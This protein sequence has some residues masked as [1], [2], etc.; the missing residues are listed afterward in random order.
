MMGVLRF[1]LAWLVVLNHVWLPVANKL[2][3]HAVIAFYAIS[4]YL[5]T[6]VL[7]ETYRGGSGLWRYAVNRF[8]R[9][10]PVYWLV[11]L[12][13]AVF[14]VAAPRSFAN[15]N[16]AIALPGTAGL[17][18]QNLSLVDL[19]YAP[20]RLVPP[21]WSL[22]V[23]CG[24]YIA[25]GL[26]LSRWAAVTAVWLVL[27]AAYAV[28]LV[29]IDAPFGDRYYPM[30]AASLFF[31]VGALA[32][33]LRGAAERLRLSRPVFLTLLAVFCVSPLIVEAL[34][35]DRYVLGYYGAFLLFLPLLAASM[36]GAPVFG[37]AIDQA[38]G[39]LAYPVFLS[40]FLALG[41]VRLVL[42]V[43]LP[44]MGVA[45]AGLTMA[46][47]MILGMTIA[48]HFD[49][50]IRRLRDAVRPGRRRVGSPDSSPAVAGGVR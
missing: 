7:S 31:S 23:E 8:L 36:A 41:L 5:M 2:G 9:I 20:T 12:V 10:F 30:A 25:M 27:S 4:G 21:A 29:W 3:A 18:L 33:H 19:I 43:S 1:T 38:L 47:T 32:Y 39:E 13:T 24:F 44:A 50:A 14:L 37:K 35:A 22:T 48:R 34:G 17:W 15:L 16:S 45:E 28:H 46:V 26:A 49:P 40:H 42:P 11:L 6:K